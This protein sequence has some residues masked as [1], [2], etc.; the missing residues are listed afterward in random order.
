VIK[1]EANTKRVAMLD[2]I[3]WF[4]AGMSLALS[5][6]LSQPVAGAVS[7]GKGLQI[8]KKKT[9]GRLRYWVFSLLKPP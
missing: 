3:Q 2:R 4:L 8:A 1:I 6:Q 7:V 9:V 5:L